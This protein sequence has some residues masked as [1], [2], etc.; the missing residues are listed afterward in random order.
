MFRVLGNK[1]PYVVT[2]GFSYTLTCQTALIRPYLVRVRGSPA[3]LSLASV[4][5]G[6]NG[7][8]VISSSSLWSASNV[9]SSCNLQNHFLSHPLSLG[10]ATLVLLPVS[11][12]L[13]DWSKLLHQDGGCHQ[14]LVNLHLQTS[15]TYHY[16]YL[17]PPWW[18]DS[19][20]CGP[21]LLR[22]GLLKMYNQCSGRVLFQ[23]VRRPSWDKWG[24]TLDAMRAAMV[25]EK[26][27]NQALLDLHILIPL[28]QIPTSAVCW[29]ITSQ[30]RRRNSWRRWTI[31]W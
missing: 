21:L 12:E 31:P 20:E 25:V 17:F 10:P 13:P 22:V 1:L 23:G 9:F 26:T 5:S 24:K 28:V 8:R 19:G 29:S 15:Y 3:D 30:M 27:R 14:R 4:V 6:W 18:C 16:E 7:L 2:C 11:Q